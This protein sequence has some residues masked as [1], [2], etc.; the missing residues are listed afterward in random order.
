MYFY[1]KGRGPLQGCAGGIAQGRAREC[2]TQE[3]AGC[4]EAAST[5]SSW[6]HRSCPD[7]FAPML[8]PLLYKPDV[9]SIEWKAL[10]EASVA[11]RVTSCAIIG[12]VRRT[13]VH[14]RLSSWSFFVRVFS[15]WRRA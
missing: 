6:P 9:N 13:A 4:A 15:A 10:E 11:Q 1:K 8:K 5:W 2:R 7:A 3:A 12:A 14:A